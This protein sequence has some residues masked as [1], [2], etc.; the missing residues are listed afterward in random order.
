MMPEPSHFKRYRMERPLCGL[1]A[2]SALPHGYW[3]IPWDDRLLH[4][5]ADAKYHCFRDDLDGRLF[6]N[7]SDPAGCRFLMESIR[8][9]PGFCPEATWLLACPEGYCGTVQGVLEAG[10]TGAI[11]NLG[12][13]PP[14]RGKGLGIALLHLA[15]RGFARVGAKRCALEV[16]AGNRPAVGLYLREGFRYTRAFYRPQPLAVRAVGI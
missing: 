7:L 10:A 9:R 12:V 4:L 6:P 5:H 11:Q 2:A 16:T 14:H 15:L 1:P 3:P 13:A 8:A